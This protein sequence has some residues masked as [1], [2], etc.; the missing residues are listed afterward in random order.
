MK[1]SLQDT[2]EFQSLTKDRLALQSLSYVVLS[3]IEI[4]TIQT[5]TWPIYC[6]VFYVL[7]TLQEIFNFTI[8]DVAD[9]YFNRFL[10]DFL[11]FLIGVYNLNLIWC[12]NV[13]SIYQGFSYYFFLFYLYANALVTVTN[14]SYFIM[15]TILFY[16]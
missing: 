1:M 15:T 2:H 3:F 4:K 13:S 14:I 12:T 9:R 10:L 7:S 8:D 5:N 16:L 6:A 11:I